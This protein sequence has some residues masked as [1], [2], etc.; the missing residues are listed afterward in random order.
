ML[1]REARHK[2]SCTVTRPPATGESG[3]VIVASDLPCSNPWPA[4]KETRALPDMAT[5]VALYEMSSDEAAFENED[6]LTLDDGTIFKI[7]RAQP[8]RSSSN[9]SPFFMLIVEKVSHV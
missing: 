8:W 1:V 7:K 4:G 6:T 2:R 9:R 5:I 3:V